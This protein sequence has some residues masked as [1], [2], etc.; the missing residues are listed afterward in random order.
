MLNSCVQAEL[1]NY[2]EYLLYTLPLIENLYPLLNM[3]VKVNTYSTY[4]LTVSEIQ[5]YQ[6]QHQ[7]Y[8]TYYY[9]QWSNNNNKGS[10]LFVLN[11]WFTRLLL[12]LFTYFFS[13]YLQN[14]SSFNRESSLIFRSCKD[15]ARKCCWKLIL[16]LL[17]LFGFVD[18]FVQLF[19]L[20]CR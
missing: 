20:L 19:S 14:V 8:F 5:W 12:W 11:L 17:L 13:T 4:L 3:R 6:Y 18:V 15:N 16:I 2:T 10:Y 1:D 7:Y 9:Y